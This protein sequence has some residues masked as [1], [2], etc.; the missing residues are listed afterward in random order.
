[1]PASS[2]NLRYD[3]I[4]EHSG[5]PRDTLLRRVGGGV[6]GAGWVEHRILGRYTP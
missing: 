5:S 3:R 4:G 2:G 6:E 1:M